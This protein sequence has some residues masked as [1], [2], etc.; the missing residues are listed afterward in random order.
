MKAMK[1]MKA[2]KTMKTMKDKVPKKAMKTMKG[3]KGKEGIKGKN[4][5]GDLF[6]NGNV[7]DKGKVTSGQ[8]AGEG[9]GV[10]SLQ[11]T[12]EH[13]GLMKG[14]ALPAK[15]AKEKALQQK[16][17]Q[18]MI[19]KRSEDTDIS[20]YLAGCAMQYRALPAAVAALLRAELKAIEAGA[21]AA[22]VSSR[23][24]E[25]NGGDEDKPAKKRRKAFEA[26]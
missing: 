14:P 23:P 10:P 2:K 17:A 22:A 11:D 8:E 24:L 21:T 4:G 26:I 19:A 18:K 15:V 20:W 3:K 25:G 13:L 9:N 6:V 1:T 7:D 5:V 16:R 12:H